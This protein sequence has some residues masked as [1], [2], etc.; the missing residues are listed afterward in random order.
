MNILSRLTVYKQNFEVVSKDKFTA[1]ELA[2]IDRAEVCN[3]DYGLSGRFYLKDG[4]MFF[5][6][7]SSEC[8][9]KLGDDINPEDVIAY[10]LKQ[11]SEGKEILR[12]DIK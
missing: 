7:L 5:I 6:D 10:T 3:G 8:P 2:V 1:E 12:M 4:G 11:G 9:L